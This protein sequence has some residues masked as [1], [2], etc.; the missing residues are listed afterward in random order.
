MGK[1]ELRPAIMDDARVLFEWRN[2]PETRANSLRPEPVEWAGHLRWLAACV[3]DSARSLY[4]AS[5]E[6][7]VLGTVRADCAGGEYELSWTVAPGQR[8]KGNGQRLV[9]ALIAT[10]PE[11]ACY[12]AVVLADNLASNRI[13]RALGMEATEVSAAQTT[14]TGRRQSP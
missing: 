5:E 12:R 11:D 8:G 6:G 9:A 13:A 3:G 1:V 14:Y 7:E 2:D 10:L 4:I